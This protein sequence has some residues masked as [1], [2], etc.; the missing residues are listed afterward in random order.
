MITTRFYEGKDKEIWD[1]LIL[2]SRSGNFLHLRSYM[3][4]HAD[5]FEDRSL[6]IESDGRPV[7]VLP[8]NSQNDDIVSHG[9]LTYGGLISTVDLRAA[10]TLEAFEKIC[11]LYR[12]V[13][14]KR[15]LY[16]AVPYV[17]HSYPSQEDLYALF[18]VG[19]KLIRRDISSVIQLDGNFKYSK[20]RKWSINK[21]KKE[22][23]LVKESI[24]MFPFHNLLSGILKKF[25]TVPTHSLAE[26]DLLKSRFPKNINLYEAHRDDCLLAGALIYDFGHT[27]HTQYLASSEIGREVGALDFLL[28]TLIEEVYPNRR[29]FSFGISTEQAGLVLNEGLAAQKEGFG[30]RAVV[31][32]LYEV[33]L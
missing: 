32:D 24:D 30:A 6:I 2:K 29:Y 25:N 17:F 19:G 3:D 11:T 7:G 12:E 8:A 28:A 20:G 21:A 22:K 16:K 4:Y 23:V 9:G 13:G 5:R 26:L 18:R 27:I 33:M 14:K 1:D 15:L 10:Q 31:H